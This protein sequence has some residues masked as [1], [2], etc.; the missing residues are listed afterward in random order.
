LEF[1]TL[2]IH[3]KKLKFSLCGGCAVLPL[4]HRK[5]VLGGTTARR[6]HRLRRAVSFSGFAE[7]DRTRMIAASCPVV[8]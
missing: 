4:A 3:Q 7:F 5:I 6:S 1:K 2:K 8:A